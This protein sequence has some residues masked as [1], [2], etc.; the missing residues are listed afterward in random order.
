[1]DLEPRVRAGAILATMAPHLS[2]VEA[3]VAS[4]PR[5]SEAT[6]ASILANV[7]GLYNF[8]KRFGD[9]R[10]LLE[11]GAPDVLRPFPSHN[12][13]NALGGLLAHPRCGRRE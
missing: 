7:S 5:N 6:I 10:A 12:F 4:P 2:H 1:M 11:R 3:W 9:S 13:V 8:A